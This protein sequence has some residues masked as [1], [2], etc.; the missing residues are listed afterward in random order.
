M[1]T[2][3]EHFFKYNEYLETAEVFII[4]K[5]FSFLF[6][7]LLKKIIFNKIKKTNFQK[8]EIFFAVIR[9]AET[10]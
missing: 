9:T 1:F 10:R 3:F 4:R 6:D 2:A 8:Y 7:N 5:M